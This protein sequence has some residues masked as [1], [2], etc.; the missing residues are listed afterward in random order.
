MQL[1]NQW[2]LCVLPFNILAG[3]D[4]V[5]PQASPVVVPGPSCSEMT[6]H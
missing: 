4:V 2:Q 5:M 1:H 3:A 6:H